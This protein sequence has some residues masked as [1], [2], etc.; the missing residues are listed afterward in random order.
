MTIQQ[1]A[2]ERRVTKSVLLALDGK[3]PICEF[4]RK[5]TN[6]CDGKG[7]CPKHPWAAPGT[8]I[9]VSMD[10]G[11]YAPQTLL[12]ISNGW[13]IIR[14]RFASISQSK[15]RKV[16]HPDRWFLELPE[17]GRVAIPRVNGVPMNPGPL[18][19]HRSECKPRYVA[20]QWWGNKHRKIESV[21]DQPPK[22]A[23]RKRRA[24]A[25]PVEV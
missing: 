11:A 18:P 2:H 12:A 23:R 7:K 16:V 15:L 17:D 22:K 1:Y 20:K 9:W 10:N 3:R 25:K 6:Q 13:A 14:P 4:D 24:K 8:V 21:L 5:A 19:L